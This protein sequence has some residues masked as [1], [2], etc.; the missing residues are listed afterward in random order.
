MQLALKRNK[1]CHKAESL[2][3]SMVLIIDA[4]LVSDCSL[5]ACGMHLSIFTGVL[6]VAGG[7][8]RNLITITSRRRCFHVSLVLL[9]IA[10]PCL[11]GTFT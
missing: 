3:F 2:L 6:V 9:L 8:G 7:L 11:D 1:R 4:N 10:S 5:Q